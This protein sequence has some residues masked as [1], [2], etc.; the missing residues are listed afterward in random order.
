MN[1]KALLIVFVWMTERPNGRSLLSCAF[2]RRSGRLLIYFHCFKLAISSLLCNLQSVPWQVLLILIFKLDFFSSKIMRPA[3]IFTG[4]EKHFTSRSHKGSLFASKGQLHNVNDVLFNGYK[5]M[6]SE[7]DNRSF[8]FWALG[9]CVCI[10][11]CHL[12][13]WKVCMVLSD[14]FWPWQ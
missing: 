11:H 14:V 10:S 6:D 8:L 13:L 4:K 2:G 12:T 9:R 1:K 5:T 3:K 7:R